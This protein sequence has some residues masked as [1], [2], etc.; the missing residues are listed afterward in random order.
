M[1]YIGTS[2]KVEMRPEIKACFHAFPDEVKT[3]LLNIR[4]MIFDAG[5]RTPEVGVIEEVLRWGQPSYITPKTKAG[6]TIRLGQS[7]AGPTALF[8]HCQTTLI[9]DFRSTFP[10]DFTYEGNRAVLIE[11]LSSEKTSILELMIKRALTYHLCK[12]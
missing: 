9:A 5:R 4:S 8:V 1:D 10:D 6:T 2:D 12:T 3:T 7:K 11:D